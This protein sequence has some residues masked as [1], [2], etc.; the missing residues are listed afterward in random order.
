LPESLDDRALLV[1]SLIASAVEGM[2]VSL[3]V[4]AGDG[5]DGNGALDVAGG[6]LTLATTGSTDTV[7]EYALSTATPRAAERADVE[8]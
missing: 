2:V 3:I 1:V 6:G 8:L 4:S 5:G 7:G